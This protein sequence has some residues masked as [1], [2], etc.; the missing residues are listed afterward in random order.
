MQNFQVGPAC[1]AKA[2]RPPSTLNQIG[3]G[4]TFAS[5]V[6][7]PNCFKLRHNDVFIER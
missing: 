2:S 3:G 6:S 1:Y 7:N 5:F 4:V